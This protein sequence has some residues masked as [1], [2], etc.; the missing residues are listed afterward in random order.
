M[1]AFLLGVYQALSML[2]HRIYLCAVLVDTRKEFSKFFQ[3]AID[4]PTGSMS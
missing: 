1:N 2:S 4:T 3:I